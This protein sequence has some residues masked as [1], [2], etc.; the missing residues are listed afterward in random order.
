MSAGNSVVVETMNQ[1]ISLCYAIGQEGIADQGWVER[2]NF[3]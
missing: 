2:C 1:A 3:E